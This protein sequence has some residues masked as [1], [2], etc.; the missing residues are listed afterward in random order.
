MYYRYLFKI[1]FKTS[2]G[3]VS[4]KHKVQKLTKKNNCFGTPIQWN[5]I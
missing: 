3:K 2:N 5:T 1:N 4:E